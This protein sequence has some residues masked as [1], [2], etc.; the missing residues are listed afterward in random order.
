MEN[1]LEGSKNGS[2]DDRSLPGGR[3][4]E[5]KDAGEGVGVGRMVGEGGIQ[6]HLWGSSLR[7]WGWGCALPPAQ[8]SLTGWDQ[9]CTSGLLDGGG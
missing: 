2:R 6:D 3:R 4:R 1:R 8:W 5:K 9:G 7:T